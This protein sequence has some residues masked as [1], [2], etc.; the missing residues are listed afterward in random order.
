MSSTIESLAQIECPKITPYNQYASSPAFVGFCNF[1][2]NYTASKLNSFLRDL[3]ANLDLENCS[4]YGFFWL[5]HYLG[6]VGGFDNVASLAS[7]NKYDNAVRYDSGACY[8]DS[9]SSVTELV[10]LK[11][12]ALIIAKWAIDWKYP[13]ANIPYFDILV[14]KLHSKL[15]GQYTPDTYPQNKRLP[16]K[17]SQE[18]STIGF[19]RL[20]VHLPNDSSG[21]WRAVCDLLNRSD[22][23]LFGLPMNSQ[24]EFKA[25]L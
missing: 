14:Q 8:D 15:G 10:A 11:P 1:S 17:Y 19:W 9:T 18:K 21:F 3:E 23:F 2:N 25:D 4:D 5:L 6:M 22:T 7:V 20:V 13:R 12:A 16:A 24:V